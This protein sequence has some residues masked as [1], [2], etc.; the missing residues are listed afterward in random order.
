MPAELDD[1]AFKCGCRKR[2]YV[3]RTANEKAHSTPYAGAASIAV[4]TEGHEQMK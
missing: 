2:R 4:V 1:V 3:E